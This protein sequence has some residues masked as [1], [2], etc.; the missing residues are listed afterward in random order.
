MGRQRRRDTP[1]TVYHVTAQGNQQRRIFFTEEDYRTYLSLL[2]ETVDRL[3]L[4]VVAYALLPNRVQL[5]CR[6]GPVPLAKVMYHLQRRFAIHH[7]RRLGVRG[8]VFADRYQAKPCEE[9]YLWVLV[10]QIHDSPAQA[11]LCYHPEDYPWS[12]CR[13]YA[14]RHW[15]LVDPREAACVLGSAAT[16]TPVCEPAA[17]TRASDGQ[18]H[19]AS[20][21]QP[22]ERWQVN[23]GRLP[24]DGPCPRAVDGARLPRPETGPAQA[25]PAR[26]P[27]AL[28]NR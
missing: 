17:Q 9:A 28:P 21:R 15:G 16:D 2:R 19:R 6:R 22:G 12:S 3:G 7:N 26:A 18:A 8:H 20:S 25:G 23:P 1:G 13:A 27:P 11:G 24:A 14:T 5:L 4:R 10:R